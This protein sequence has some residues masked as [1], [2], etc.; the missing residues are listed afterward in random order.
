M[1]QRVPAAIAGLSDVTNGFLGIRKRGDTKQ[2]HELVCYPVFCRSGRVCSVTCSVSERSCSVDL[3]RS[4]IRRI[5]YHFRKEQTEI[6]QDSND[7]DICN[8]F[9]LPVLFETKDDGYGY[10]GKNPDNEDIGNITKDRPSCFNRGLDAPVEHA[11]LDNG[12]IHEPIEEKTCQCEEQATEPDKRGS[13]ERHERSEHTR[14]RAPHERKGAGTGGRLGLV[15][16]TL[17]VTHCVKL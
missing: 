11:E 7:K 5:D 14:E 13:S 17:R 1:T 16:I 6:N 15:H 12:V 8:H 9:F 10:E 3:S 2:I 4:V